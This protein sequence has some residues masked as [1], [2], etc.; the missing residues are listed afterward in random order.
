MLRYFTHL[1]TYGSNA[2]LCYVFVFFG[3]YARFD[4]NI[5]G[6]HAHLHY[7]DL[8]KMTVAPMPIYIIRIPRSSTYMNCFALKFMSMSSNVLLGYVLILSIYGPRSGI[9]M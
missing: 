6:S 5:C 3:Y 1:S 7:T 8:I 4:G 2:Y 9:K